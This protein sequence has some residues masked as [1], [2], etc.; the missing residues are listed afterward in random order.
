MMVALDNADS[1]FGSSSATS[2][3]PGTGGDATGWRPPPAGTVAGCWTARSVPGRPDPGRPDPG[4]AKLPAR[5]S[6]GATLTVASAAAETPAASTRIS[7]TP[8]LTWLPGRIWELSTLG[9]VDLDPI[10]ALEVVDVPA[11]TVAAHRRVPAR[12][13][14]VGEDDLVLA[15]ATEAD[16]RRGERQDA[17]FFI[18]GEMKPSIAVTWAQSEDT[19]AG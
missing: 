4:A 13:R 2:G 5:E 14:V 15:A 9:L 6:T 16:L 19:R 8:I 7:N 17:L 18:D 10:G 11:L 1:R 12:H 3:G